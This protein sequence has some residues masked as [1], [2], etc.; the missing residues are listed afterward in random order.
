MSDA[1]LFLELDSLLSAVVGQLTPV[2]RRRLTRT[3]SKGLRER[4]AGR[5]RRQLNPDGS[6]FA[7]RKTREIKTYIGHMRFLWARG[8]QVREIS[9]W[10]HGKGANGEPVITGYD[11]Q[12]GGF[13][14]FKR[15]DIDE[16]LHIDLNKTAIRRNLRQGL[17]FQRIR[18]YRFLHARSATDSAEV[19][20]DG[21]AA[22]IARIHQFGL[23]DDLSEHFRAKYPVRELLGL[24]EEDLQWIADTIYAHLNPAR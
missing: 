2:S 14:T 11:A 6:R 24:A 20:F 7:P 1:Q 5:I 4:Q 8:H 9:N 10:R 19:G 15:A 23:V 22:A 16:F 18:A 13:R 21:K 3:L 12:A 17:M